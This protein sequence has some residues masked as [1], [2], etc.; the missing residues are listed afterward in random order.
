[1]GPQRTSRP[2]RVTRARGRPLAAVSA[3]HGRKRCDWR[4]ARHTD[5]DPA[6]PRP[7]VICAEIHPACS[8]TAGSLDCTAQPCRNPHCQRSARARAERAEISRLVDSAPPLSD[9]Q[10]AR[11]AELLDDMTGELSRHGHVDRGGVMGFER[12]ERELPSAGIERVCAER[13]YHADD[14]SGEAAPATGRSLP[15]TQPLSAIQS[16]TSPGWRSSGPARCRQSQ[17]M[18]HGTAQPDPVIPAFEDLYIHLAAAFRPCPVRGNVYL[19]M[20]ESLR[21][22]EFCAR[23]DTRPSGARC[24]AT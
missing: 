22:C 19:F 24:K 21:S 5:R 11:L 2:A 15:Y 12:A 6:V 14:L 18:H 20:T 9:A 7:C 13:I 23:G 8:F 1:M 17:R 4:A 3:G 10:R 16:A